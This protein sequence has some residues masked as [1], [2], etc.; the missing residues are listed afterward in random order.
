MI[1]QN[2][3]KIAAEELAGPLPEIFNQCILEKYWPSP[4][5]KGEWIPVFKKEDPLEKSNYRPIAILTVVNKVFEQLLSK[6]ISKFLEPI[7]D[8]FM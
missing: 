7:F 1:S 4:W 6:Q 3:L 8:P 5:K 2:V